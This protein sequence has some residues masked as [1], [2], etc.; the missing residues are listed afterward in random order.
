MKT[1]KTD[2]KSNDD[3]LATV[4]LG[5]PQSRPVTNRPERSVRTGRARGPRPAPSLTV[6]DGTVQLHPNGFGF[7]AHTDPAGIV[8]S[9]FVRPGLTRGLLSGDKV[10]F[11]P[12]V[13]SPQD[14]MR[15]S[16][17]VH[18]IASIDRSSSILLCEVFDSAEGAARQLIP[19]EPCSVAVEARA[20]FAEAA[21]GDVLAIRVPA[22]AGAPS[23][24]PIVGELVRN[25]GQRT[26]PDF[27]L[28]YAQAKYGFD[29]ELPEDLLAEDPIAMTLA[30]RLENMADIG[31]E[32]HVPDMSPVPYVTIDSE[33]TQDFDDAVHVQRSADGW[34]VRVAISDVARFVTPGGALDRW[35]AARGTSVY[36]PGRKLPMLPE[37]LSHGAC[38]LQQGVPRY[39]VVQTLTL[40]EEGAV[41]D[42]QFAREMIMVHG[43]LSYHQVADFMLH[44]APIT[45]GI[46]DIELVDVQA[47]GDN[48]HALTE[49]YVLLAQRRL[50]K[51][52]MDFEEPDPLPEQVDGQWR[53]RWAERTVAHKLVEELMLTA[54][55]SAA[56]HLVKRYGAGLFRHQPAPGPAAW[57]EL[58]AWAKSKGH[59]LPE[60]PSIQAMTTLATQQKSADAQAA[61]VMKL[62]SAMRPAK[63]VA[64]TSSAPG[65]HFSLDFNWYTHFTSPIRRYADLL[66]HR[67]LTAPADFQLTPQAFDE[68]VVK[69]AQCS[70]RALAA[71]LA[72]RFVLDRVKLDTVMAAVRENV[73][74]TFHARVIRQNLR[75]VKVLISGWQTVAWLGGRQLCEAGYVWEREAWLAPHATGATALEEGSSINVRVLHL[76]AERPAYPELQ[77]AVA[78]R[79]PEKVAQIAEI[80]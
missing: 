12:A 21:L 50:A 9:Y 64:Q 6:L 24:A 51:G 40:D 72:E 77:V 11:V 62:R 45:K 26:R 36:L 3:F 29:A 57:S 30:E 71:K 17:S 75:G 20:G 23:F 59:D 52:L 74:E 34:L 35:A 13:Q 80:G 48:V 41:R 37:A 58:R 55:Q 67:L 49:L 22:F 60:V 69:V 4:S 66:V 8:E 15:D 31:G 5:A 46:G 38:S 19:D 63:Y 44:G 65:G 61:A 79:V 28:D 18:E 47:V 39:A 73:A 43:Q 7:V 68:L 42:V 33:S 32:Q 14:L 53:M 10:R 78:G 76:A 27:H 16:R 1:R 56:T 2:Q 70:N 25:L 54:N